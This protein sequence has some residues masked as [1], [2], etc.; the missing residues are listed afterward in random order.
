MRRNRFVKRNRSVRNSEHLTEKQKI[1]Q[2]NCSIQDHIN[3]VE[4]DSIRDRRIVIQ[5]SENIHH[6]DSLI[7]CE[8]E[9][10]FH[11]DFVEHRHCV[12]RI[13]SSIDSNRVD[14]NRI[15]FDLNKNRFEH[16]NNDSDANQF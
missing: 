6:F 12:S 11:F 2:H 15:D 7:N 10:D 4:C 3:G 8:F 9:N 5:N 1:F 13:D 16:L 14:R